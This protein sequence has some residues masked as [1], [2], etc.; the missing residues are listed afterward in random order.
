MPAQE[1]VTLVSSEA[2][3]PQKKVEDLIELLTRVKTKFSGKDRPGL[4][5]IDSALRRAQQ[6]QTDLKK[7]NR[8]V[9]WKKIGKVI[10]FLTELAVAI[11]SLLSYCLNFR[12]RHASRQ[13]Y[14]IVAGIRGTFPTDSR[15]FVECRS[16]LLIAA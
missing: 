8:K 16:S 2:D 5:E 15:G 1:K 13:S 3:P 14:K 12:G 4:V 7:N 9:D 6:L 10:Q 11:H